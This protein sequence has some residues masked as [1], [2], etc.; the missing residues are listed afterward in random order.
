MFLTYLVPVEIWLQV[1]FVHNQEADIVNG[2]I[3]E[4]HT[5]IGLLCFLHWI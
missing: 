3:N 5:F 2:T 1:V 4:E